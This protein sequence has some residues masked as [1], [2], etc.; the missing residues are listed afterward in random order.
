MGGNISRTNK[1]KQATTH[2][3]RPTAACNYCS[4]HKEKSAQITTKNER[5]NVG[6][7]ADVLRWLKLIASTYRLSLWCLS[8]PLPLHAG[9][10]RNSSPPKNCLLLRSA[11]SHRLTA[12][13]SSWEERVRLSMRDDA[14]KTGGAVPISGCGYHSHL[15]SRPFSYPYF[16]NQG[17]DKCHSDCGGP[18]AGLVT[19]RSHMA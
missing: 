11:Y 10:R 12:H 5:E 16:P 17:N 4:M 7:L 9:P 3:L 19:A 6:A 18:I 13:F 2:R 15:T 14:L 1:C 8:R